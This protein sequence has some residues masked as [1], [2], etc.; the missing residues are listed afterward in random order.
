METVTDKVGYRQS[1]QSPGDI[2]RQNPVLKSLL[3]QR[4]ISFAIVVNRL[5]AEN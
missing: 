2:S 1:Y 5:G 3:P 4:F